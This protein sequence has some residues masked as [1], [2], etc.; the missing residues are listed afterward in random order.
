MKR[1]SCLLVTASV[2]LVGCSSEV[3]APKIVPV[4]GTV[5][6]NGQPLNNAE[7][8]FIPTIEGL[9]GHNAFG[10]T[11]DKGEFTLEILGKGPGCCACECKVAINEGPNQALEERDETLSDEAMNAA[12]RFKRSLKNRPIPTKYSLLSKTPFTFEVN[13]EGENKF[14]LKLER[15]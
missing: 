12:L 15:K 4:S 1:L 10:I 14:E 3:A 9:V 2:I 8:K 6:I 11:N 7:V 5:T 13:E